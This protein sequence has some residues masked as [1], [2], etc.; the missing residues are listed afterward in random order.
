MNLF[1]IPTT[2]L[3]SLVSYISREMEKDNIV[4]MSEDYFRGKLGLPPS[5]L[6]LK[7]EPVE[8]EILPF[9]G[10]SDQVLVTNLNEL[11]VAYLSPDCKIKV[12]GLVPSLE[13]NR[14]LSLS[15]EQVNY[16]RSKGIG[17]VLD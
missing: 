6:S 10:R 12:F 8:L 3:E 13:D 17:T 4:F 16:L 2:T 9:R 1:G 15:R 14:I 7:R 11:F 5:Y